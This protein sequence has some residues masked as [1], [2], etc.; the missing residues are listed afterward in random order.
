[1]DDVATP[2]PPAW[3]WIVAVLALLWEAAGCYFYIVQVSMDAADLAQLPPA[4]AEAFSS[5]ATWQWSIFAIAVWSGLLGAIGL[6][7]RSRWAGTAFWVSL[8]AAAV[9]YGYTLFATPLMERM[10]AS[11]ALPLPVSIIVLGVILVWFAGM[12]A[13]KGWL[14]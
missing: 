14:R 12:A 5:M 13:N 3:Y 10:P 9:Q 4:Q 6:L 2:A 1:M 8:I 11:E 7:V